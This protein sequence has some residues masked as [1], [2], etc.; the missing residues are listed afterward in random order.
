MMQIIGIALVV[1][2][3]HIANVES[4]LFGPALPRANLIS[5][6]VGSLQMVTK[7]DITMP[8]LSSTM[9]EGRIVS[10]AKKVGDK[11]QSGEVL[12]VVESD[13]ADMDVE[14]FEDG[15]L[16][17]IYTPEGGIAPVGAVVAS[18]VENADIANIGAATAPVENAPVAAAVPPPAAQAATQAAPAGNA[19]NFEQILMPALSSTMKEGKVV[20][21]SKKV[22]DKISSG[23]MVLVV[24]SD[25]ADMDVESYEEGYLAAVLVGDGQAAPV[26]APVAYLAKNKEDIAAI[27]AFVQ[28]GGQAA[29]PNTGAPASSAP[30]PAASTGAPASAP[31][32]TAPVVNDGR[33]VASGYA[34]QLAQQQGID[35]RTVTPSRPDQYITSQDLSTGSAGS[36]K[37]IP[38]PGTINASPVARKLAQE[39]NLQLANIVGTGNFGRVL[40]EDVLRAAGKLPPVV[41]ASAEVT[42]A[43]KSETKAAAPAPASSA[44]NKKESATTATPTGTV[45]MNA[46]Q[47][48][49]AK[50]MEK[51]MS[52]PIFRIS[53]EIATDKFDELYAQLKP[54]GVTVSAMLAKALGMVMAKHPLINANY[55]D[56]AVQYHP[57]VNVAMAVAIDGGL[58]TPVIPKCQS[59]D[60]FSISRVWKEL[61]EKAKG[62]K[63]TPAEY[64]TGTITI[65][66]LG[67]FGVNQFDAILPSGMGTILAISSSIP[68]VVPTANGFFAV[69]KLMTVTITC[70]HR[71]IY[72]AHGAEFLRDLADL[73]ENNPQSLTM[74]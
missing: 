41:V 2:V 30:S 36:I 40:P 43:A 28:S 33:I 29:S 35:L 66:N 14:S 67:M 22:G 63:L 6:R 57:D 39:N 20:S 21:W 46:M 60:L 58:I 38:A 31:A 32:A 72:G 54:K 23:D 1:A 56:G 24:E 3:L 16:A 53:K 26:G 15:Y 74:G 49:V 34:K 17:A 4:F 45:P 50:N 8:A 25:K 64:T 13:K 42:S 68:K 5:K 59:Q 37:H 51:T 9:K 71:H 65:S 10:W 55:V 11:V 61:V 52:V 7:K 47:K 48:A 70:D 62:K 44:S 12:L 73:I 19:P 69:K 18:L 27:Q